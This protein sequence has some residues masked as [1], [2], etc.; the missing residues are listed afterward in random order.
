LRRVVLRG[1]AQAPEQRWP[2]MRALLS[3]LADDDSA[4]RRYERFAIAGVVGL[5]ATA[6]V[7]LV[8][9]IRQDTQTCTGMQEK[10]DGVWDAERRT[11]IEGGLLGTGLAHAPATWARVEQ[12][13]DDYAKAWVAARIE[14]CKATRRGEQSGA[15]LDLRMACLDERLD[16]L[17]AAVDVLAHADETVTAKAVSLVAALPSLERCADLNAL[18]A[19][20]PPPDDPVTAERVAEL[21]RTLVDAAALELAGKYT[22]ALALADRVAAAS[23]NLDYPPLTA[24]ALLRQGSLQERVG[25]Y[26]RAEAT[27]VQAYGSALAQGML[28]EA[29]DASVK[30]MFLIGDT[31]ARTD[32]GLRWAIDADALSLAVHDDQSRASYLN[33]RGALAGTSGAYDEARRDYDDARVLLERAVGPEHPSVAATLYNLGNIA[34]EQGQLAQGRAYHERALAIYETTLG[35]E[36]PEVAGCLVNRAGIDI[37]LGQFDQARADLERSLA[38]LEPALGPAHPEIATSLN[39]LGGVAGMQGDYEEAR[40]YYER[41]LTI[42]EAA[43]GPKHPHVATVRSNLGDV[44]AAL[45]EHD[46]ARHQF[47]QALAIREAALGT[48]HP[49][50]AKSLANLGHLALDERREADARALF[51][52]ALAIQ[53][54]TQPDH[55]DVAHVRFGLARA[56][57]S[58]DPVHA[59]ELAELARQTYANSTPVPPQLAELDAYLLSRR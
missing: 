11:Q 37:A 10:L 33:T 58:T 19:E 18:T 52:R 7:G 12:R 26:A 59:R 5:L 13:L 47:E 43:L 39:G 15:L 14:T 24:R 31:L 17:Q 41:T 23:T 25:D 45:G 36:H 6:S 53:L 55:I 34:I 1:L 22:E 50:V 56:S 32:E 44:A 42:I 48:E 40:G 35:P 46:E 29:A 54:A 3:A 28:D 16:H 2:S 27:I 57:W 4:A 49:D 21:E 20:V 30:L 8:L 9:A 38:I 51:E